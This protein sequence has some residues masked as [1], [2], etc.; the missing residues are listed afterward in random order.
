M[1]RPNILFIQCDQMTAA[2]LPAAGNTVV[3]A[4]HLDRLAREGVMFR[5]A[6]CP[7]PLCVPSRAA[8]MTGALPS[9]TGAYDN[10][11]EFPAGIPTMAHYLRLQGYHTQ[12][13][14]KMH[15]IGPDQ[16]HGYEDRPVTDVYP[17]GFDWVPD[18]TLGEDDRL[19]WYHDMSS[20]LRAGPLD[21]AL[22]I[23][24]DQ[25]VAFRAQRALVD[26]ARDRSRPFFITTSFT[27]PHDPFEV[28]PSYW[29]AYEGL[30]IDP[31]RVPAIPFDQQDPHSQRL[32]KMMEADKVDPRP[33]QVLNARRGYYAAV[34]Y[35]DAMTGELIGLLESLGLTDNTVVVFT[36]DHGEMLGERG[37]W[38]KM[39]PFEGSASVPLIF[40]SKAR[41]Q[42]RE[43]DQPVSILDLLP[44]LVEIG[45]GHSGRHLPFAIDGESLLPLLRGEIGAQHGD[46]VMEYLGE[47]VHAPMVMMVRGPYKF[48]RC[49][50]D[51][52]LLF[53]VVDDPFE[54]DNLTGDPR[55]Q[56]VY[57]EM[58]EAVELR[59]EF[60]TLTADVLASQARRRVVAEALT[61][62]RIHR[63]DH[64]T[65]DDAAWRYVRTG[66][67]FWATHERRRL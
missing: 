6:Y 4:P 25:E 60:D 29:N 52:D 14:G 45:G 3:K 12:L 40:W 11:G 64:P 24:Y 61:Q 50:G 13:I 16:L 28:P 8:M 44:T 54:L 33:D 43:V 38:Y 7:S 27:F 66:D 1:D 9:R 46:V 31:P 37:L 20:V 35:V 30:T 51:P 49:P 56:G 21:A 58:A 15:F 55:H 36:S 18:W 32:A 62:G 59:W 26:A 41:F 47:G 19:A 34:S 65:P 42:P 22:Q 5:R 57:G 39:S 67:D 23:D 2:A 10:A 63:W 53:D 17:A 48:V